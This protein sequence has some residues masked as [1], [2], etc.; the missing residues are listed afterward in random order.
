VEVITVK[1]FFQGLLVLNPGHIDPG[2]NR[3]VFNADR[4]LFLTR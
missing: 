4:K 3:E 2:F 1:R